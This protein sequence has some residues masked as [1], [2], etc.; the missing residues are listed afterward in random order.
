MGSWIHYTYLTRDI[1]IWA[2]TAEER[3]AMKRKWVCDR[4]EAGRRVKKDLPVQGE[5][6]W[7]DGIHQPIDGILPKNA[8]SRHGFVNEIWVPSYTSEIRLYD[9]LYLGVHQDLP[10]GCGVTVF[11]V[12][13]G[14]D[15]EVLL[16]SPRK[17]KIVPFLRESQLNL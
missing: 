12:W 11:Y 5:L 17:L 2:S 7:P 3:I 13:N 6:K 15:E 14:F 4:L 16:L 8:I 1:G 9:Q 10:I